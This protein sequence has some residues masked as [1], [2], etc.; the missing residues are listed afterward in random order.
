[1]KPAYVETETSQVIY[2]GESNSTASNVRQVSRESVKNDWRD[3]KTDEAADWSHTFP[4]SLLRVGSMRRLGS[5]C[6]WDHDQ[7]T[8]ETNLCVV[9]E[10]SK[11]I[12]DPN[13]HFLCE[14]GTSKCRTYC[15]L[16]RNTMTW[17]FAHT[18]QPLGALPLPL[19]YVRQKNKAQADDA[20]GTS[21]G[22][23]AWRLLHR[24]RGIFWSTSGKY[25]T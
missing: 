13:P 12:L 7:T 14:D 25:G 23:E 20:H 17:L 11:D 21:T 4:S 15:P 8:G 1:M 24:I 2:V 3:Q 10:T 18:V 16:L 9:Q 22:A 5:P 19:S 6:Q